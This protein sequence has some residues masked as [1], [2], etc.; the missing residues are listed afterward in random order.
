MQKCAM[1]FQASPEQAAPFALALDLIVRG[2]ADGE[3]RSYENAK[4]AWFCAAF[5][6]HD[7]KTVV[8]CLDELNWMKI[9]TREDQ[10]EI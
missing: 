6:L 2:L 9:M 8:D 7:R 5:R 3:V 1:Y 10:Y 4:A